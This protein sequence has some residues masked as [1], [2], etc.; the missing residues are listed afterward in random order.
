MGSNPWPKTPKMTRIDFAYIARIIS[1][2]DEAEELAIAFSYHLAD[3]NPQ[4]NRERF[5]QACCARR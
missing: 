4:F 3:T 1:D 5:I 2:L